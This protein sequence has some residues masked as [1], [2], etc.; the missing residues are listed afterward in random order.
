MEYFILYF[1]NFLNNN[2]KKGFL[3]IIYSLEEE[4][5]GGCLEV[6]GVILMNNLSTISTLKNKIC[7]HKLDGLI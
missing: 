4:Y 6:F 1:G 2:N 5:S 3:Y 7:Y